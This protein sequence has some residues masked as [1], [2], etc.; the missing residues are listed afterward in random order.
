[1]LPDTPS[2]VSPVQATGGDHI[3]ELEIDLLSNLLKV[4]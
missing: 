1:M 2:E 3:P 4:F